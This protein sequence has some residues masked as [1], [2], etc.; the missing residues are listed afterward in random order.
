M[1][2]GE[3][4]ATFRH[5]CC[6]VFPSPYPRPCPKCP[7]IL[8]YTHPTVPGA[9]GHK[10]QEITHKNGGGHRED[11]PNLVG[12]PPDCFCREGG[13]KVSSPVCVVPHSSAFCHVEVPFSGRGG[14]LSKP[15]QTC[16]AVKGVLMSRSSLLTA[17]PEALAPS[18]ACTF[19]HP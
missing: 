14:G 5:H 3:D 6:L 8:S 17:F 4:C 13:E 16:S 2:G 15:L 10:H 12:Q 7:V 18:W 19:T 11:V 1:G 9:Q